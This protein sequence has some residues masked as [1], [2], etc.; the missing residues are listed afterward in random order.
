MDGSYNRKRAT[1]LSGVGWIFFYT[2]MGY[3]ITGSFWERSILANSYRA[4]LLGLCALHFLALMVAEF[5]KLDKWSAMLCCNNKQALEKSS[6]DRSWIRPSTK[7]ADIRRSLRRTQPLLRGFFCYVH[8]YGHMDR[9]LK[10]EQLTLT[11]K[12]NCVC[13]TLVKKSIT[14]VFTQGCH[15]KMTRLLP[16]EDVAM[17]IWGNKITGNISLLICFHASKELALKYLTTQ[18]KK[19][20]TCTVWFSRLGTFRL[21]P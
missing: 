6:H 18:R 15:G 21:H 11:Q 5:Y 19:M 10:W 8:V 3:C 7:C 20:V 4:E 13:N 1:N 9:H 2:R 12:L 17:L 14:L 16:N